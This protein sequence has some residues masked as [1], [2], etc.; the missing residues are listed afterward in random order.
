MSHRLSIVLFVLLSLVAGN[1]RTETADP[2]EPLTLARAI[3]IGLKNQPSIA[4]GIS[5]V[6]TN[7]A[8]VGEA[9]AGYY[10]QVNLNGSYNRIGPSSGD[11]GK[12]SGSAAEAFGLL[13]SGGGAFDQYTSSA[14][15]SQLI[16][17]FGKTGSQV[18]IQS[19]TTDSSRSDLE[20]TMNQVTFNIKQAYYGELQAEQNRNAA[21]EAVKQF[22]EHLAQ[23]RGFYDVGTKPKF[24]VTK[25]EVD[26]SNAQLA[27]IK[28]EN[29]V[30]LSRV[31]LNN[32]MGIPDAQPYIL[33]DALIFAPFEMAF[34]EALQKA[35]DRN[36]DLKSIMAKKEAAR[37]TIN[38]YQKDYF[39]VLSGNAG[40]AYSGTEFP[41]EESWNLGLN[42]TFPL[43]SG[44]LTKYQVAGAQSSL[45]TVEA[46]E[47]SL[48][49][50]ILLQVQQ[51]YLNLREAA[52]RTT[53][54]ELV[55]RQTR[56][57]L[58]LANGRYQ[59]GVGSPV[60]VT[61]A[62][63]TV[64]TSQVAY[65]SALYDY[66]VAASTIERILGVR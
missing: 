3:E 2:G 58:D 18:K 7:Q 44:F 65:T 55:I 32:A 41:L 23:A 13:T 4:A 35:Y 19:L 63:V 50:D 21:L 66:K 52:E 33:K 36:A 34:E 53:T 61:D 22:R 6:K 17:D 20:S 45:N 46:N 10:P 25:A 9:R 39:P 47:R 59:A 24:D 26:L 54:A 56:E 62:V 15:L 37:E 43:F 40:Y 11:S 27:L 1:A 48:R 51:A 8:R 64:A 16:F 57:N 14:S 12:Q 5:T 49:N 38:F 42:L 60:D 31:T 30:R 28:T 29:N